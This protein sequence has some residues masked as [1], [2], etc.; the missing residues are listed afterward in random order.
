MNRLDNLK[1][2]NV[3]GAFIT[4]GD[5][6]VEKTEEYILAMIAGG[7]DFI[8]IGIPFSDPVAEDSTIQEA[9]IKA[10]KN[11]VNTDTIFDCVRRLRQDTDI[12]VVAITNANPV[13][14]YSEGIEKFF[15]NCKEAG[16]DAIIMPDVPFEEV[17]EFKGAAD[18][19]GVY[20][21]MAV[22]P[23]D[24]ERIKKIVSDAHGFVYATALAENTK[25]DME[26]LIKNVKKYKDIPVLTK[27]ERFSCD[28]L[29]LSNEIVKLVNRGMGAM[30]IS[31]FVKSYK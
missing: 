26:K 3:L 4:P 5:I 10:M 13:F 19:N 8:E 2:E 7:A 6:D 22:A 27:D 31:H 18:K 28:G 20:I 23:T 12:P 1:K 16:V 24:E 9:Y 25:E 15:E 30:A 29:I 21:I 11:C 17:D 14:S